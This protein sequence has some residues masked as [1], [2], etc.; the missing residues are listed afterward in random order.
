M[1]TYFLAIVGTLVVAVLLQQSAGAQPS[2]SFD[3]SEHNRRSQIDRLVRQIDQQEQTREAVVNDSND[4]KNILLKLSPELTARDFSAESR[5]MLELAFRN[6][7]TKENLL[8]AEVAGVEWIDQEVEKYAEGRID[9]PA[10]GMFY[11]TLPWAAN[12]VLARRGSDESLQKVLAASRAAD[13]QS[14]V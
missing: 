2:R 12:L 5:R 1:R 9:Q 13:V 7:P 14:Q 10:S 3:T 6:D 4:P 11:G 8:L